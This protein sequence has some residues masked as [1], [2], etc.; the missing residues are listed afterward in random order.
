MLEIIKILTFTKESYKANENDYEIGDINMDDVEKL[1][2]MKFLRKLKATKKSYGYP[3]Y[4][5]TSK[6]N[7]LL[8]KS[9][10]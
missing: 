10:N 6:G 4:K 5:I 3:E 7:K 8:K 9:K 2:N 1:V